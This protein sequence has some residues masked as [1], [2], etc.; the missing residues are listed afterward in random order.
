MKYNENKV[1]LGFFV[2]AQPIY[3][4]IFFYACRYPCACE[5]KG[6]F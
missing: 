4:N 6:F 5:F 3:Y 1:F 2:K